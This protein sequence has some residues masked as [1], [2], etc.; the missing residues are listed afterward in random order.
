M[1]MLRS[2]YPHR[3]VAVYDP[4]TEVP[5]A[6][7]EGTPA[8][9]N[10]RW[11]PADDPWA[12]VVRCGPGHSLTYEQARRL[13][14]TLEKLWLV[15]GMDITAEAMLDAARGRSDVADIAE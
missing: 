2:D 14:A 13:A 8:T 12:D 15:L 7:L 10:I 9:I 1:T 5:F 3:A 6:I 4:D 11:S